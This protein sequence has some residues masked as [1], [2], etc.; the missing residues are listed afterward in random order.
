MTVEQIAWAAF[1]FGIATGMAVMHLL[2]LY[3]NN[4]D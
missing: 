1:A 4:G 2:H 3:R